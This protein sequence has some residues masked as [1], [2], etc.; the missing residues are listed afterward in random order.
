[1][2]KRSALSIAGELRKIRRAFANVRGDPT[3]TDAAARLAVLRCRFR[4]LN[5]RIGADPAPTPDNIRALSELRQLS[6][7]A[8]KLEKQMSWGAVGAGSNPFLTFAMTA[9]ALV[10]RQ[11]GAVID[12]AAEALPAGKQLHAGLLSR[13][14]SDA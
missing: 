3:L 8:T 9:R 13:R 11:A 7:A 2:G 14:D 5:E 10:S 4:E 12:G 1:M 6:A